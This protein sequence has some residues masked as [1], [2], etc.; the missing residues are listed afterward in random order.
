MTIHEVRFER[1]RHS[2][3]NKRG[4]FKERCASTA[5][6]TC[7]CG[8]NT[9]L[10]PWEQADRIAEAHVDEVGLPDPLRELRRF[11]KRTA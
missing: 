7:T 1:Q 8:L 4:K 2:V 9:G 10:I 5:T 3:I 6:T 11:L